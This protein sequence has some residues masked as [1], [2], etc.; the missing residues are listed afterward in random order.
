LALFAERGEE[1]VILAVVVLLLLYGK[2]YL[3]NCFWM[4]YKGEIHSSRM[5]F[6]SGGDTGTIISFVGR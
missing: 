5:V 4:G 6:L 3:V 1:K 2:Q